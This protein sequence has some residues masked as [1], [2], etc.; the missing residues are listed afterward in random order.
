MRMALNGEMEYIT[1]A[2]PVTTIAVSAWSSS[3]SISAL[4]GLKQ[5]APGECDSDRGHYARSQGEVPASATASEDEYSDHSRSDSSGGESQEE[6]D[7]FEE[8]E[9]LA[10]DF[11]ELHGATL[12]GSPTTK[13]AAFLV[14][15]LPPD[16]RTKNCML[17]GLWFGSH[18]DMSLFMAK[19]VDELN[20]CGAQRYMLSTVGD[21]RNSEDVRRDMRF[22]VEV[23]EPVNGLKGP[24]PLMRLKHFDLV[25]GYTVDYMHCVLLGVAKCFTDCWLDSTNSQEP[26]YIGRPTTVAEIDARLMGIKPPHSFTRLPRSLKERCHWKASEWRSWLLFYA[27]PCCLGILPQRYLNHFMLL[28][29]GIFV[30]LQEELTESQLLRAG[31]LLQDFVS[32]TLT[33]YGPRMMTF[34]HHQLLHLVTAARNFGPL[35]AHSAFVFEHGNGKVLRTVT[36]AKGVPQQVLERMVML[37]QLELAMTFFPLQRK[38][39]NFADTLLGHP[40]TTSATHVNGACM[41]GSCVPSPVLSNEEENALSLVFGYVPSVQEHFRFF[42]KGTMFTSTRYTRARKS[43]SSV[44]QT[45]EGNFFVIDRI[46]VVMNGGHENSD[47]VLISKRLVCTG[48]GRRLPPHIKD[49]FFSQSSVVA[50]AISDV[51]APCLLI[52]FVAEAQAYVCILPNLVERD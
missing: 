2:E 10:S 18:P 12:P 50:L 11:S 34:N 35:W 3:S 41:F 1:S 51:V 45:K 42:F 49:C 31:R 43:N 37:Q 6:G 44:V 24:S 4:K 33:L 27:V 29:E 17:G 47:C 48:E 25:S 15:E 52:E 26:F 5:G 21:L 20:Q 28:A 23:G 40:L 13:A 7:N 38:V 39:A 8:E 46:L 16:A 30:L 32:R 14:N 19:F 9:L 36:S 22:A